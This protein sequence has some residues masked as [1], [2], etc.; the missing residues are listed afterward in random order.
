MRT[1]TFLV[2]FFIILLFISI[3]LILINFKNIKKFNNLNENKETMLDL[4]GV[5]SRNNNLH[6]SKFGAYEENQITYGSLDMKP[7]W[8]KSGNKIVFFR[9]IEYAKP[10]NDFTKWKTSICIINPDGTSFKKMT[11]GNFPDYNPTWSRDG[12]NN[13]IFSRYNASAYKSY[14]Y[15]SGLKTSPDEEILVSDL[16]YSEFAF[17]GLKDGRIL[18][19]STRNWDNKEV[20]YLF[21]PN[22]GGLG[23][24]EPLKFDFKL[25]GF[26]DRITLSPGETKIVYEYKKGWKPFIYTGKIIYIADFNIKTLTVSNPKAITTTKP[27]YNSVTLYPTWT[28]DEKGVI[29]YCD[30]TGK[31]Q[32]Y[33]YDLK[34]GNTYKISK[35][36]NADY[37]FPCAEGTPK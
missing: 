25:E 12:K 5:Y 18:I 9:I 20:Y 28:N 22:P 16:K 34:D 31:N 33:L 10:F 21:T 7:S 13:I 35:N 27:K 37:K 14:I 4:K 32:L 26:M 2:L 1:K 6:V 36:N 11:K 8:T 19:S 15:I 24:Y 30:K 29:Y 3:F 23:K 17:S